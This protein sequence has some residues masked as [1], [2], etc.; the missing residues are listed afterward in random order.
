MDALKLDPAA[1]AAYTTI[2]E[3]VSQ[4]L[5]S[6]SAVAAGAMN[7]EQLTTDLGLIGAGFAARFTAAVAEHSQ[8]L[9][10]AGQ[11]VSTYGQVLSGYSGEAQRVDADTAG[12]VGRAGEALA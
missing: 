2:A 9:S 4:Q 7:Q 11:L 3:A 8:A 12:A 6:A 10:T 1:M 5:A